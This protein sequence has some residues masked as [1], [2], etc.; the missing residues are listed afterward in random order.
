M[1]CQA[2]RLCQRCCG[3]Y[4]QCMPKQSNSGSGSARQPV[5]VSSGAE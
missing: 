3:S 4:T 2:G 5:G 1:R